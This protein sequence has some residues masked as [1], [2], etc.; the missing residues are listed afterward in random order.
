MGRVSAQPEGKAHSSVRR[1][2][3]K[4]PA[5]ETSSASPD[6][7]LVLLLLL[8]LFLPLFLL[9]LLLLL[10]PVFLLVLRSPTEDQL[11]DSLA[12]GDRR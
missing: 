3:Q 2:Q 9:L 5:A 8:P 10:L 11:E 4:T 7:P 12:F 6:Q 1:P